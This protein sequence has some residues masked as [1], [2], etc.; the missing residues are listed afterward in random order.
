MHGSIDQGWKAITLDRDGDYFAMVDEDK[1][2]ELMQW[3]WHL[4]NWKGKLY[5]KRTKRKDDD[6]R[7]PKSIYM[8]IHLA[9]KYIIQPSKKHIIVDH[10]RSN[11]L[12]NRL[13][14]LRWATPQDNRRNV[15][16]MW[17]QQ[18][19]LFKTMGIE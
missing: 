17:W 14:H 19:D 12:D 2:D 11:G 18:K 13:K 6:W 4:Y 8:H 1:Y 9:K 16:G 15:W 5:A 7:L 3:K 10:V